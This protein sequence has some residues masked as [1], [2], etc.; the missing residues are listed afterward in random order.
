MFVHK[1][2]LRDVNLSSDFTRATEADSLYRGVLFSDEISC[3]VYDV[4]KFSS[5]VTETFF[6]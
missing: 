2:A 3:F 5:P 4:G 6:F 1:L